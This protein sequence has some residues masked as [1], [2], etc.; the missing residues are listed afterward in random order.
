MDRVNHVKVI[1][2][3]PQAVN[4]FLTEVLDIPAGWPMPGDGPSRSPRVQTVAKADGTLAW[5]DVIAFRGG[6]QSDG[7][8]TGSPRS[9][10]F[11]VYPGDQPKI[12]GVAV[13]TRDVV[14]AHERATARGIPCTPIEGVPWQN[15]GTIRAFFAEVGGIIFEVLT[16][17]TPAT[18][19]VREIV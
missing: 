12:W 15:G 18:T 4:S 19:E 2:P 3:D 9:V 16:V 7:F 11:Q 17:E 13:G 14:G 1:T 6:S 10:Q 8:I 5:D